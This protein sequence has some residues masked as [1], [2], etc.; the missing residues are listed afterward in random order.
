MFTASGLRVRFLEVKEAATTTSC[1]G[2]DICANRATARV[3]TR[4]DARERLD[5]LRGVIT[6]AR[7][8]TK[9]SSRLAAS[10]LS[11]SSE[12]NHSRASQCVACAHRSRANQ[13][14]Q[15]GC[16]FTTRVSSFAVGFALASAGSFYVIREDIRKIY[17]SVATECRDLVA[18]VRALEAKAK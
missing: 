4:F 18:R 11:L 3:R 14:G 13:H 17:E 9:S 16:M 2:F 7:L 15:N 1:V 10:S 6:R 12:L 5:I 8:V